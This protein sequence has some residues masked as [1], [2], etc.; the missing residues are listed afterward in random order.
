MPEDTDKIIEI[1]TISLRTLSASYNSTQIE[2]LVRS[3]A[4]YRFLRDEIIVVAEHQNEIDGA[5]SSIG[6]NHLAAKL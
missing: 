5:A 3:Q 4:S 6:W 1:Q 2:S